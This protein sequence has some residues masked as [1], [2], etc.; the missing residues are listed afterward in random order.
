MSLWLKAIF[1]DTGMV[2]TPE[3]AIAK[4]YD[5]LPG[6]ERPSFIPA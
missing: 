4:I 3:Q 6:I 1:W 2:K 5:F